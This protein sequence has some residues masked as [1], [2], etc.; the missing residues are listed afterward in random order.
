MAISTKAKEIL[1]RPDLIKQRDLWF[2]RMQTVFLSG[3]SSWNQQYILGV[4]GIVGVGKHNPYTEP[5]L[6]VEDCLEDLATRYEA[7]ENNIYFRP[8]CVEYPVYGVHYIDKML[9][10]NVYFYEGQWYNDYLPTPI[11]QLTS[12]DLQQDEVWSIT[13]RAVNAFLEADVALP[14]FGLPT[15]ASALNIAVNLY[16]GEI[17]MEML[18][19]PDNASAD[20][21]TINN[22]LCE[23]HTTL[24]GMIP[25]QQLQPVISWNRTQPPGY[26]QLCGCTTQLLSPSLYE[27]FIAPLD[28]KLL[29]VYPHGGMIH[30]C[31]SHTQ[32]LDT[33]RKMKSLK[34]LQLNDRAAADLSIYFEQLREDQIIYLNPCK[35]LSIEKALEI[36]H[37]ERLI[38]AADLD[39]PIC[40]PKE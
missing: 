10:A 5:E 15:I 32:H 16:G 22:L 28:E 19:E 20:L 3:T 36:T 25:M 12:P 13:K 29:S 21:T 2:E 30:L 35:E 14:L 34:A 24:R 6:W 23:L 9:G 27:E 4:N 39:A 1:N 18:T 38:I 11:G 31:G 17:L 37:G 26:G 7:L 40:R 33:F 8:L